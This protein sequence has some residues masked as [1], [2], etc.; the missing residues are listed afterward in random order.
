M[1]KKSLSL[2]EKP[3]KEENSEVVV[4]REF[5]RQVLPLDVSCLGSEH[6][7][8]AMAGTE[9]LWGSPHWQ[10]GSTGKPSSHTVGC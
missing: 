6:V 5:D 7:G 9:R 10:L 1:R 2:P 3:N 4:W 8:E